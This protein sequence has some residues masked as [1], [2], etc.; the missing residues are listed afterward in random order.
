MDNRLCLSGFN[1]GNLFTE[2]GNYE[3][4]CLIRTDM[5]KCPNRQDV[6]M[7][8]IGI[9]LPDHILA[10]LGGCIDI[11]GTGSISF[12]NRCFLRKDMTILFAGSDQQNAGRVV[13][14]TDG[15]Q[16]INGSLDIYVNSQGRILPGYADRTLS[17]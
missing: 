13:K 4:R 10:C 5:I 1:H 8:S 7:I 15:F 2:V 14:C 12:P 11:A 6:H 3:N 9:N 17:C 16:Y